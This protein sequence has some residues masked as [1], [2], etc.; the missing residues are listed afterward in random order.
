MLSYCKVSEVNVLK[1]FIHGMIVVII[2]VM[3]NI[4][5][6]MFLNLS[7]LMYQDFVNGNLQIYYCNPF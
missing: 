6:E 3:I 1:L 7:T 4:Y 2:M 5:H